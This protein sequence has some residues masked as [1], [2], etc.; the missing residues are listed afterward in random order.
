ML[1]DLNIPQKPVP[2]KV[3]SISETIDQKDKEILLNAVMNPDWPMT[4]L[5][6]ELLKRDIQVSEQSIRRHRTK[7]CSCWKI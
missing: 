1:E 3:R 7:V 2:C 4:T 6:R 5:A